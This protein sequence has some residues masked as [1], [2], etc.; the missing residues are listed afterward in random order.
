LEF[1]ELREAGDRILHPFLDLHEG[2]ECLPVGMQDPRVADPF[3]LRRFDCG[4]QLLGCPRHLGDAV[5]L[6]LGLRH[7][8]SHHGP[9]FAVELVAAVPAKTRQQSRL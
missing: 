1:L 9:P 3:G 6:E 4:E 7:E 5:G 8:H 2:G